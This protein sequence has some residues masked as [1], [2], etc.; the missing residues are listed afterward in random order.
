MKKKVLKLEKK[1]I[2]QL[3]EM[4]NLVGGQG[5]EGEVSGKETVTCTQPAVSCICNPTSMNC[6]DNV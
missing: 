1:S 5:S 4:N 2:L 6:C 3:G